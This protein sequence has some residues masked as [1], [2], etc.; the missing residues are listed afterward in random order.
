MS[1]LKKY[2]PY[3]GYYQFNMVITGSMRCHFGI[4][5]ASKFIRYTEAFPLRYLHVNVRSFE[6]H[7]RANW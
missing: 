7:S 4:D 5:N 3:E 6:K 2:S 1:D